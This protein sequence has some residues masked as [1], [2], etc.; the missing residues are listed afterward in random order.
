MCPTTEIAIQQG[1][2]ASVASSGGA[3]VAPSLSGIASSETATTSD[4]TTN[5]TP[6]ECV[7]FVPALS[8]AIVEY[9]AFLRHQMRS[10]QQRHE[11]QHAF[12]PPQRRQQHH[13]EVMVA[14][15][16]RTI[17]SQPER[18]KCR[19]NKKHGKSLQGTATAV[20]KEMAFRA[21]KGAVA[22]KNYPS[23]PQA[24]PPQVVSDVATFSDQP[25]TLE[26]ALDL[27]DTPRLLL[28][29]ASPHRIIHINAA[30]SKQVVGIGGG[31]RRGNTS[32]NT[33]RGSTTAAGCAQDWMEEQNSIKHLSSKGN[34][35]YS[36]SLQ[37]A[38]EDI[39]PDNC[40]IP[41]TCYP[42]VVSGAAASC[43]FSSQPPQ[44][45]ITH[46]LI[47]ATTRPR[48]VTAAAKTTPSEKKNHPLIR[49][50]NVHNHYRGNERLELS[51]RQR[52]NVNNIHQE[53]M[54]MY[55]PFGAVG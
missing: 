21:S 25:Y 24:C 11:L 27:T 41:F 1:A 12:S 34:T 20:T 39:I 30:F 31:S 6:Q 49:T 48:K 2:I 26:D 15:E 36:R 55:K 28:E 29:A 47:E 53:T 4:C 37:K 16:N 54:E 13:Q 9:F 19:S 14:N 22:T 23:A 33:R 32:R 38:I 45:H 5:A 40:T 44:P 3:G 43:G 51:P 10:A 8:D 52:N 18:T 46:Y 50:S 42:V 17:S 35:E 7:S